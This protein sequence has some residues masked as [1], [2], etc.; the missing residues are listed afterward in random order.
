[1]DLGHGLSLGSICNTSH[2]AFPGLWAAD[3]GNIKLLKQTISIGDVDKMAD[4]HTHE[5]GVK[6]YGCEGILSSI[7]F[8]EDL[9]IDSRV[10]ASTPV[11]DPANSVTKFSLPKLSI[12]EIDFINLQDGRAMVAD[13]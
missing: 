10:G 2:K 8:V 4:T 1:M 13:P 3:K 9:D 11:V 6:K 12:H 5:N 7:V